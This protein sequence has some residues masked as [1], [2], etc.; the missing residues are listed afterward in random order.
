MINGLS[1]SNLVFEILPFE[2]GMLC[3]AQ[4]LFTAGKKRGCF[5]KTAGNKQILTTEI[6]KKERFF[7]FVEGQHK[8]SVELILLILRKSQKS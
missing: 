1:K 6:G 7:I 5:L 3:L 8:T 4:M 2:I